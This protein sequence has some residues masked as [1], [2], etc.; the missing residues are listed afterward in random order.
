MLEKGL[1]YAQFKKRFRTKADV[2]GKFQ[3][4]VDTVQ[5]HRLL[6]VRNT[7][8]IYPNQAYDEYLDTNE[9]QI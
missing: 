5:L 8:K 4:D 9:T 3:I 1:C 6:L 7:V 2:Y